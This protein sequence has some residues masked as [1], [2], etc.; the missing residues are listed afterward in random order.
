MKNRSTG[1]CLFEVVYIKQPQL[2][3]DLTS[4]ATTMDLNKETEMMLENIEKLHNEVYDHIVQPSNS[5]EKSA[6]KKRR[7]IDVS[8]GDLVMVH[9]KEEE[10]SY[11]HL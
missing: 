10:L 5:Y 11:W 1:K 7:Q 3:F 8:K 2:T 9:L 6:D 4:L